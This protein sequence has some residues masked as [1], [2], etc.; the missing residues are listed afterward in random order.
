MFVFGWLRLVVFEILLS[1][2][3]SAGVGSV[4]GGGV[5]A[6]THTLSL[7][8]KVPLL[9]VDQGLLLLRGFR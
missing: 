6:F 1:G 9:Y 2:F 3:S 4:V 8:K 5:G 7:N